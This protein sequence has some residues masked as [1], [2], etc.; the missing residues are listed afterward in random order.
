MSFIPWFKRRNLTILKRTFLVQVNLRIRI[1]SNY[2]MHYRQWWR[3]T[4]CRCVGKMYIQFAFFYTYKTLHFLLRKEIDI[5]WDCMVK[6]EW[7]TADR[8]RQL[9]YRKNK[10]DSSIIKIVTMWDFDFRIFINIY[11]HYIH[12]FIVLYCIGFALVTVI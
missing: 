4:W 11:I 7:L 2:C 8:H 3:I 9:E 10:I 5:Q 6:Y 1:K 12:H